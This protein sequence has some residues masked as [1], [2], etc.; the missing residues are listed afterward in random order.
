MKAFSGRLLTSFIGLAL[1]SCV[2]PASHAGIVSFTNRADFEAALKPGAYTEAKMYDTYPNYSGM[3][4]SYTATAKGGGYSV[5]DDLSTSKPGYISFTFEPR[6]TAFGGYFY[7]T[8]SNSDLTSDQF[9]ISLN[10]GDFDVQVSSPDSTSFYG[11][12]SDVDFNNALIL[13]NLYPVAGS[14][15]VGSAAPVIVPG[16]L[17]LL[18]AG[19]AFGLSRRLRRR[20]AVGH[21]LS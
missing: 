16:P 1:F 19:A 18:G 12:I 8:D 10:D 2:S 17:P 14:V 3:G 15:I 21:S 4:F 5:G 20:R 11:F 13:S 7:N 9:S 6:I